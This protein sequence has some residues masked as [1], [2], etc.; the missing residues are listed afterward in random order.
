LPL[1]EAIIEEL[2]KNDC[3]VILTTHN[4]GLMTNKLLRPDCYF[5]M[6]KHKIVSMAN[7]TLKE[8][9]Q[10]HNIEKMYR[11]GAFDA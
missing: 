2:K 5:F 3:Q 8:L 11:N 4:S 6:Y 10:A 7:S 9:R 1:A